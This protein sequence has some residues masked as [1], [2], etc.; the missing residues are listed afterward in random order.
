MYPSLEM[1]YSVD[2]ENQKKIT[3]I[4][5]YFCWRHHFFPEILEDETWR[6]V[7]SGDVNMSDFHKNL[8]I[9]LL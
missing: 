6:L 7:T 1:Y 5:A 2:F 3:P 9:C 4:F 8:R